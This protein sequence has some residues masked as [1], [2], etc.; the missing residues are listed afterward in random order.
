MALINCPECSKQISDK[1]G[2][3]PQC[4]FPIKESTVKKNINQAISTISESA[5]SIAASLARRKAKFKA[6]LI[7]S[8]IL[9]F[10][11]LLFQLVVYLGAI[12]M[13]IYSITLFK[14]VHIVWKRITART[15]KKSE[16]PP[17]ISSSPKPDDDTR[18]MPPETRHKRNIVS[19]NVVSNVL[20]NATDMSKDAK[21]S[22][23]E[24]NLGAYLRRATMFFILFAL[25]SIILRFFLA[26]YI[27]ESV[28]KSNQGQQPSILDNDPKK[29]IGSSN[30]S[31]TVAS[32]LKKPSDVAFS[33]NKG[34]SNLVNAIIPKAVNTNLPGLAT[35]DGMRQTVEVSSRCSFSYPIGFMELQAKSF[36]HV[37]KNYTESVSAVTQEVNNTTVRLQQKGLSV[38]DPSACKTFLRVI[39]SEDFVVSQPFTNLHSISQLNSEEV[40]AFNQRYEVSMEQLVSKYSKAGQQFKLIAGPLSEQCIINGI[41]VLKTTTKL[42]I[43]STTV[44]IQCQHFFIQGNRQYTIT[45]QFREKEFDRWE[46]PVSEVINSIKF[47]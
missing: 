10:G 23:Q 33:V 29:Q 47:K 19:E 9:F 38:R 15:S 4:G 13:V 5:S 7:C 46:G 39:V 41:S 22:G 37:T 12:C 1:A 40:A 36:D 44:I 35:V 14:T 6:F 24:I 3:C 43:D 18:F 31:V 20:P 21:S 17:V 42:Q 45:S 2:I 11:A 28:L 27:R 32:S 26:Q 16:V 8:L 25:I 34:S 30:E